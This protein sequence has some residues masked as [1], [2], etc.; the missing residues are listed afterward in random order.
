MLGVSELCRNPSK[1]EIFR[2]G[3]WVSG[4]W[5]LGGGGWRAGY[6]RYGEW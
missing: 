1:G 4:A 3:E 5:G 6:T 2:V